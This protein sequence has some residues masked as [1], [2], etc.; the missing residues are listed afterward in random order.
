MLEA[1]HTGP[2]RRK[3]NMTM[4]P[5]DAAIPPQPDSDFYD[6]LGGWISGG[7]WWTDSGPAGVLAAL[8]ADFPQFQIWPEVTLNRLR[9]ISVSTSLDLNPHTVVTDSLAEMRAVLQ[10]ALPSAQ[11]SSA[12]SPPAGD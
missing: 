10:S 2:L 5:H 6:R 9:Y 1:H 11:P 12:Q 8:Q 4:K 3:Q 7:C